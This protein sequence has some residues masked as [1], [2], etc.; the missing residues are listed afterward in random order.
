MK[1]ALLLLVLVLSGCQSFVDN[2]QKLTGFS[3]KLNDSY[4]NSNESD[5]W[6]L[7]A[8]RQ[9]IRSDVNP[10]IQE[11][12]DWIEQH[13]EY[14][15][16]ISKRAEPYLYVVVSEVQK[17]GL[18]IEIALLP[19]VESD[20][21]PFSYSHGTA[22]GL[23][24]FIPSTG[25]MYGLEENWWH[26]DRRDILASTRAAVKYLKDLN[27]MF[28]GDW[29]MAIAAYNSGPGRVQK[30]I[31]ANIELGL[32][33]DF[34]SINLPKE[35]E[36]YVPKLLALGKV[37]KDPERY[38]QK[39]F[40]IE[41]KPFLK[42]IELNSQF[43]LALISQWTGLTIDQIY[44]F[45]PGLK[46]WATPVSLPYTILLPE[47]VVNRFEE[48]LSKAGQR[49]KIS[50]ARHKV[51]QGDSLS[52][53][54][55]KYKTTIGQIK[56][57]NELSTD[58]IR[59][60][61]YLIVPLA[62]QADS[63]YSLSEN[64]REKSRLNIQKNAEKIIYKVISGDSLWKI[65]GKYNTSVN[66]LVRWNQIIPTAPLS[67]GKELVILIENKNK[68]ELAKIANTGIDISR[69]IVYTVKAGDNLSKIAKKYQVKV[70]DIRSWNELNEEHILQPGDKLTITINVVNSN[71]S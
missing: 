50:W 30:A 36:K 48:N 39:L 29:L 37:I 28:N 47:D 52:L 54:A 8:S 4:Q 17:Q 7:I 57:V 11:H 19:I 1:S 64:Q 43:D 41:N 5:L 22:V 32:K 15:S 45:N 13:P 63:Y 44:T 55:Q 68:T 60:G 9:E 24:Q 61:D 65:A 23:W 26:E 42:A 49:P 18:P 27:E 70:N 35:T 12:I 66:D 40:V 16:I 56:S 34:W 20:Y 53:I 21:Y 10:R 59:I 69:K 25:K 71:L 38:N 6:R 51:K 14:L 67:I 46:R 62:Q 31:N 33:A 3:Q 58:I 2:N